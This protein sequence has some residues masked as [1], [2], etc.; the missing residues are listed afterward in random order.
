MSDRGGVNSRSMA[1]FASRFV[2]RTGVAA[3]ED[4]TTISFA[5][6]PTS[7]VSVSFLDRNY[8]SGEILTIV[9]DKFGTFQL[10]ATSGGDL[11]G[12]R[13]YADKTIAVFSGNKVSQVG[14]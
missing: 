4:D 11:T 1:Y 13:V 10:Q 8:R 9:L 14:K 3:V 12:C 6:P 7:N 2:C 5:V